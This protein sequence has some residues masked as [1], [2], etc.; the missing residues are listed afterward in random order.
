MKGKISDILKTFE[1]ISDRY[2][3][4]AGAMSTVGANAFQQ[5]DFNR[6]TEIQKDVKL[7]LDERDKLL[8]QVT[9][10][11]ALIIKRFEFNDVLKINK[12]NE[13]KTF[14]EKGVEYIA[15][16]IGESFLHL[17]TYNQHQK[18]HHLK[19]LFP[20]GKE[21][22]Q[23][24]SAVESAENLL[25]MEKELVLSINH[26]GENTSLAL[27]LYKKDY[28]DKEFFARVFLRDKSCERCFKRI[29]RDID[30]SLCFECSKIEDDRLDNT[31]P[32]NIQSPFLQEHLYNK[33]FLNE[34]YHK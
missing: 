12:F 26:D 16:V 22:H 25:S 13:G 19:K 30:I 18:K 3:A 17:M 10:S 34:G 1:P 29:S 32:K 9:E 6:S 15:V 28:S 23:I 27:D 8:D 4:L 24:F 31:I 11:L 20:A 21:F 7:I 5:M 33:F 14:I 2:I